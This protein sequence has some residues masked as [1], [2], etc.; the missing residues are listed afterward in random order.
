M[1]GDEAKKQCPDIQLV[2][3]PN[4]R[5][6]ADLSKYRE[7]GKNVARVLQRFTPLLERAS[8][9]EAYMDITNLVNKRHEAMND[10]SK[11]YWI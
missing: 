2:R 5:E 9:D 8:V 4:I 11:V 10:V 7:A 6:K 3:V 1:R